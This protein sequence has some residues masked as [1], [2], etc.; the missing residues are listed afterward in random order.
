[1][2]KTERERE[3]ERVVVLVVKFGTLYLSS[4]V[5]DRSVRYLNTQ[6]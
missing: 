5:P 2:R 1:M 3:G 4:K 6:H